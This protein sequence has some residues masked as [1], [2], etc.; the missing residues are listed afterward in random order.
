[1]MR[2][3]SL[4]SGIGG[5]ES[6]RVHP[7]LCCEVDKTCRFVLAR[8]FRNSELADDV[9]TLSPPA[10]DVVV[11]GWPCQDI[12]VAGLQL[13]LEGSRSGLFYQ[14]LRIARES[15]AHTIIAEN[16]PN[17][18]HLRGGTLFVEVLRA[19]DDSGFPN[20]A[21]RTLNAREFG[22]PH[23]RRRVFLI[24]SK[25]AELAFALHRDLPQIETSPRTS[26]IAPSFC[27]GF[28]WTAGLQSICY[29]EGYVPTLK[30]GSA[31]SIPSPP[32]LHFDSCVRKATAQECLRLQGFDP[33]E[34]VGLADKELYRMAGNAVAS[35]VG[36][37]VMDSVF[38]DQPPRVVRTAYA[39]IGES[40]I[41]ESGAVWEVGVDQRP[42]ATN[43]R[44]V[45][46]GSNTTP[47]SSRAASG[48]LARLRRSGKPCPSALLQLLEEVAGMEV[49]GEE[50]DM[51]SDLSPPVQPDG[52]NPDELD[53]KQLCFF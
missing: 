4:F 3:I 27:N 25:T 6:S 30:V 14:M 5:L 48:L 46:D 43:L 42:L 39:R 13:G 16:V 21:W 2:Y 19:L 40:G 1:M 17:L 33:S 11:G 47:M 24:A 34:F 23:E 29:S 31:L 37:F 41:Y 32:A 22:L 9:T 35:P 20:V 45:I 49:E 50:E 38:E 28:Y 26:T 7:V 15:G 36:R 51:E 52:R 44:E 10:A 18:L 12:S 53:T 8:R